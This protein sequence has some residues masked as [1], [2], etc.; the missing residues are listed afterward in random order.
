MVW[1][2]VVER[3]PEPKRQKFLADVR[4]K[5]NLLIAFMEETWK[6]EF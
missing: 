4:R 2:E 5:S 6:A 1:R 3:L